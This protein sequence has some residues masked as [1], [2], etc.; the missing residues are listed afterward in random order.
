MYFFFDQDEDLMADISPTAVIGF[1]GCAATDNASIASSGGGG[2]GSNIQEIAANTEGGG[3]GGGDDNTGVPMST[4]A[5][6]E[7]EP[8]NVAPS[9]S[10]SSAMAPWE[11]QDVLLSNAGLPEANPLLDFGEMEEDFQKMLNDWEN[12]IG[13]G[14][15][16]LPH[17]SSAD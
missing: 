11:H 5:K 1:D 16:T 10:A 12:H 8:G 17:V 14:P 3:D 15:T 7:S 2:D 6:S 13:I 4:L 9:S